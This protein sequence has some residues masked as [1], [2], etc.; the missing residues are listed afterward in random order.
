MIQFILDNKA[1]LLGFLLALSELL[2]LTSL[3]S[4]SVFQLIVN[5]LKKAKDA[6]GPKPEAT[7]AE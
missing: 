6:V 1:V 5:A 7:K 3:K 2:A 4:N